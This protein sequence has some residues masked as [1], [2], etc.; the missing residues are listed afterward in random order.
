MGLPDKSLNVLIVDDQQRMRWT[1]KEMLRRIGY[2][3]FL[4]ADDGDVA[5]DRLRYQAVDLV[6]SDW[7]M[8]RMTGVDVLK[9]IREDDQLRSLP[10]VMITAE[11]NE[12]IV[13]EAGEY[14]V[15]AY[16]LK[17]FTLGSLE[18]KV[19]EALERR[20]SL[21]PIDTHLELGLTYLRAG[22][23]EKALSEYQEALKINSNSPRTLLALGLV[24][25]RQGN[26]VRALECYEKA[27][28][29]QPKYLKGHEALAKLHQR[30][31]R[32]DEAARHLK[33]AAAISPKN[34]ERHFQL[35]QALMSTGQAQE[36]S[37]VLKTVM[38]VAKG[39]YSD[40]ARRVGEAMMT[41][42]LAGEA[43]D[44]FKQALEANPQDIHLFN[45]LG[46]AFRKQGKFREAVENY[47][48]ALSIAPDNEA[49]FFNLA[50][51]QLDA[52]DR[53]AA[54]RALSKA[55][56]LKPDFEEARELASTL[57][58]G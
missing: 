37:K 17:P 29:L 30:L 44:A 46:I 2:Q 19:N 43:E 26:D 15:D 33:E 3:N 31:N 34:V 27:I 28:K 20:R 5:L 7:R 55:L 40:V 24:F 53:D 52:G 48:R 51:A 8:P 58:A 16:L 47:H 36:A 22:Q 45:R 50:R 38:K 12:D 25:E 18:E 39:Q 9:F 32:L 6:L 42:G 35:A 57:M 1:I 41:M 21:T 14:E 11:V 10:F 23:F 49:L 4:E 56:T 13:A 54:L